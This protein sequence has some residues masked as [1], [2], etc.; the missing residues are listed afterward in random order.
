VRNRNLSCKKNDDEIEF[1]R[2]GFT[3][4]RRSAL[5]LSLS[6][7][8]ALKKE[9]KEKKGGKSRSKTW[10][11]ERSKKIRGKTLLFSLSRH[12]FSLNTFLHRGTLIACPFVPSVPSSPPRKASHVCAWRGWSGQCAGKQ[13]RG[14]T[15]DRKRGQSKKER[16][17]EV[18]ATASDDCFHSSDGALALSCALSCL[19]L[20]R[21]ASHLVP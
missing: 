11:R 21:E 2:G 6:P 16:K 13:E 15:G 12:S 19:A 10:G 5:S 17:R 14:R 18:S 9:R 7:T 1:M 20:L 8:S 4:P 3:S